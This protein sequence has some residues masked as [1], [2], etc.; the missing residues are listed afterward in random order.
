MSKLKS[1]LFNGALALMM[2]LAMLV[3]VGTTTVSAADEEVFDGNP[4]ITKE[5]KKDAGTTTPDI[6]IVYTI[7]KKGFN[8]SSEIA[9]LPNIGSVTLGFDENSDV[10]DNGD[11]TLTVT[12]T[13]T[14][15]LPAIGSGGFERAGEYIYTI[16]ETES[17]ISSDHD[18]MTA[19]GVEYEMHVYVINDN[20]LKSA[21]VAV[22]KVKDDTGATITPVK[23]E[24]GETES[25]IPFSAVYRKIAGSEN[26][27]ADANGYTSF[28]VGKT[29]TGDLGDVDQEFE[30]TLNFK[31]SPLHTATGTYTYIVKEGSTVVST[32]SFTLGGASTTAQ[33]VVDLKH[34]Q[35][36]VVKDVPTGTTF[37]GVETGFGSYTPAAVVTSNGSSAT[38]DGTK[39]ANM[40]ISSDGTADYTTLLG[41]N[42]NGAT[43][44]NDY[45]STSITGIF[46]DNLPFIILIAVG[47]AGFG[48][49][50]VNRKRNA[51]R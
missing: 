21:G 50:A 3:T 32:D 51:V 15:V 19:S 12:E 5:I 10:T 42:A 30:F 20:G 29:V 48:F 25:T 43:V 23:I 4:T 41:E 6:D 38:F 24:G 7:T 33:I 14:I 45:K 49:Y 8:A 22:Y 34:G 13:G 40:N 44:T 46:L 31:S 2:M 17:S 39:G 9:Y 18:S 37:Y 36:V 11:S 1:R 35:E 16:K 47:V 26:A 28:S 27:T